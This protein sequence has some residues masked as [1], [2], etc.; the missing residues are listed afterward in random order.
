MASFDDLNVVEAAKKIY[1]D[2][3]K[4]E[5]DGGNKGVTDVSAWWLKR[6]RLSDEEMLRRAKL[7]KG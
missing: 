7:M 5:A 3:Q 6:P 1:A 4:D 2:T